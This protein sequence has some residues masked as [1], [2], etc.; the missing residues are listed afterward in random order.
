MIRPLVIAIVGAIAGAGLAFGFQTLRPPAAETE[1]P[2]GSDAGE[3]AGLTACEQVSAL[4]AEISQ[5]KIQVRDGKVELAEVEGRAAEVVGAPAPWPGAAPDPTASLTAS[6]EKHG[7]T[8][9]ALDCSENPCVHASLFVGPGA[10]ADAFVAEGTPQGH[11]RLTSLAGNNAENVPH[12]FLVRTIDG[13]ESIDGPTATRIQYRMRQA[14]AAGIQ[15]IT[16]EPL[17]PG[18]LE[19]G[20]KLTEDEATGEGSADEP[21]T[22]EE[23]GE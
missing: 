2:A 9:L 22:P 4:K 7:G 6:L 15:R 1:P 3:L 17:D 5:L 11:V 19:L 16:F 13:P 10:D 21:A 23:G 14:Y 12:K 20:W 18:N 8:L